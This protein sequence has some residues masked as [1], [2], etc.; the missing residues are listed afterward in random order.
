MISMVVG[1]ANSVSWHKALAVSFL[2]SL[3]FHVTTVFS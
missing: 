2:S 1:L 3:E